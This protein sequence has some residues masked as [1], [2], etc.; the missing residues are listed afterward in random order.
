MKWISIILIAALLIGGGIFYWQRLQTSKIIS[1]F[2]PDSPSATITPWTA[3]TPTD[4]TILYNTRRSLFKYGKNGQNYEAVPDLAKTAT[5]KDRIHWTITLNPDITAS[6]VIS[7][8]S[9]TLKNGNPT[10]V[11][12][13]FFY[14]D[15]GQNYKNGTGSFSGLK[16]NSE[17]SLT[18]VTTFPLNL[19]LLLADPIFSTTVTTPISYSDGKLYFSSGKQIVFT[20][21]KEKA[22]IAW[23]DGDTFFSGTFDYVISSTVL[24]VHTVTVDGLNVPVAELSSVQTYTPSAFYIPPSKPSVGKASLYPWQLDYPSDEAFKLGMAVLLNDPNVV[25]STQNLEALMHK[26]L[27]YVAEPELFSVLEKPRVSNL[28][29]YLDIMDFSNITK[30]VL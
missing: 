29:I 13:L 14:I 24:P 3:I 18:V 25:S 23:T 17:N 5:S 28:G 22:D 2:M 11:G 8:W 4:K 21:E 6:Q 10:I 20:N 26:Y 15:G 12:K 7:T 19:P 1:V 27:I 16:A 9:Q 30:K